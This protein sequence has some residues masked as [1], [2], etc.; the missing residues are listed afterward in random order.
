MILK[1]G[2]HPKL[3]II[4]HLLKKG[5]SKEGTKAFTY[6]IFA[7]FSKKQETSNNQGS[8]YHPNNFRYYIHHVA[9]FLPLPKQNLAS[10]MLPSLPRP[11]LVITDSS[12][13]NVFIY[14]CLHSNGSC[15]RCRW[16]TVQDH[17][18]LCCTG[19]YGLS[20]QQCSQ[21]AFHSVGL[22]GATVFL[23]CL[24]FVIKHYGGT[25]QWLFFLMF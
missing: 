8:A 25:D 21:N 14:V 9:T 4:W 11:N 22:F 1:K 2:S 3:S 6:H 20:K 12:L 24:F 19:F 13:E 15:T 17:R 7:C 10:D 18:G 23:N 16:V 5:S